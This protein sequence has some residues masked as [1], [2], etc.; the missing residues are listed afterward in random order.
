MKVGIFSDIQIH[1]WPNFAR[2]SDLV[3][4]VNTRAM[5]IFNVLNEIVH[6]D[7]ELLLFCGDLFEARGSISIPLLRMTQVILQDRGMPILAIPGNHD[8]TSKFGDSTSVLD[9]F[10]NEMYVLYGET[11]ERYKGLRVT[12]V[13]Y[14]WDF[15]DVDTGDES[16]DG[17]LLMHVT[18]K[19]TNISRQYVAEHGMDLD[20][21]KQFMSDHNYKFCFAGDIH[22]RQNL[23]DG[24]YY[25]GNPIQHGFGEEE[26][27][28]IYVLDTDTWEA[29]FK[30]IKSPQ[31]FTVEKDFEYT[32]DDFYQVKAATDK[33]YNELRV[34]FNN[35]SNVTI[36]PPNTRGLKKDRESIGL[37][38][39]P[40]E[41]FK[42][43]L[44]LKKFDKQ[45]RKQLVTIASI[46]LKDVA[47]Q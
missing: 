23:G 31:F 29:R 32:E 26:E 25:V 36:L 33:E 13:P 2:P 8:F 40:M 27:K 34:K 16:I 44:A 20:K 45:D 41:A 47:S 3:Q 21:V 42:Q 15:E 5:D 12:G 46:I 24:V 11:D 1:N 38:S 39:K 17:V 22:V 7:Y 30:P 19:G 37:A 28:G 10:E 18:F 43:W 14:G 35:I 4:G 9:I 6:G